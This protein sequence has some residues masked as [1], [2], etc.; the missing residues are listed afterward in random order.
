[1]TPTIS[2]FG[3]FAPML[4]RYLHTLGAKADRRAL[5]ERSIAGVA[6]TTVTE[7]GGT[8]NA[9]DRRR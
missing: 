5:M 8:I 4:R 2:D 7:S 6:T 9:R 1:V 3:A